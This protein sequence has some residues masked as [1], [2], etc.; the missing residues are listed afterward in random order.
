MTHEVIVLGAGPAGSVVARRLAA[1]GVCVALIGMAPRAGWEGVSDRSRVLLAEEGIEPGEDL[2]S[3]AV[4]AAGKLGRPRGRGREWLV[5]RARL[6][7][8]LRE[9]AVSAG[10]EARAATVTGVA[11]EGAANGGSSRATAAC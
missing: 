1:S 5:E 4:H 10:A 2:L 3:G 6:A 7:S 11:R 8:S 9:R